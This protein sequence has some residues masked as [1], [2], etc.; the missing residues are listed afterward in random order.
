MNVYKPVLTPWQQERVN[1]GRIALVNRWNKAPFTDGQSK[2]FEA[3]FAREL[4]DGDGGVDK[5]C[6]LNRSGTLSVKWAQEAEREGFRL[7][8][9]RNSFTVYVPHSYYLKKRGACMSWDR[10]CCGEVTVAVLVAVS[11]LALGLGMSGEL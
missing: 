1:S 10:Q 11:F 9:D 3:Y 6:V 5:F 2:D 7:E 4:V 8:H